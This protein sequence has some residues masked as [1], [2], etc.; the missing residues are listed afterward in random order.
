MSVTFLLIVAH[1]VLHQMV[2]YLTRIGSGSK[3]YN[4]VDIEFQILDGVK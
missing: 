1:M 3:I 4:K 2:Q